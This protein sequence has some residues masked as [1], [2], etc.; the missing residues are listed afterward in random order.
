MYAKTNDKY[1]VCKDYCIAHHDV[2][3]CFLPTCK[4]PIILFRQF[5]ELLQKSDTFCSTYQLV[6]CLYT[7]FRY[8]FNGKIFA[9]SRK[10]FDNVQ[11][12]VSFN[13]TNREV[14][15]MLK[16]AKKRL[17]RKEFKQRFLSALRYNKSTQTNGSMFAERVEKAIKIEFEL[18]LI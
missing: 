2:K 11:R 14:D 3:T 18:E 1:I 9:K 7:L 5:D 16:I 17:L 10:V 15:K 6:D 12:G 13:Q 4:Y 8:R